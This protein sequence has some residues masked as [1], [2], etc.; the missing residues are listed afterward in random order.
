MSTTF[1]NNYIGRWPNWV[2]LINEYIWL[3]IPL[4]AIS[5][6]NTITL[7]CDKLSFFPI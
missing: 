6:E 3:A 5:S 2:S 1:A 4:F 7:Q